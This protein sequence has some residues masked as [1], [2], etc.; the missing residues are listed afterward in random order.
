[1][2]RHPLLKELHELGLEKREN[3]RDVQAD[4]AAQC[5]VLFESGL[6][7]LALFVVHDED[8]VGPIEHVRVDTHEGIGARSRGTDVEVGALA[9]QPLSRRAP[10]SVL[11]ADEQHATRRLVGHRLVDSGNLS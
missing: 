5:R 10:F 8:H 2:P 9:E 6:E 11:P 3:V 7:P 1:M 4:D